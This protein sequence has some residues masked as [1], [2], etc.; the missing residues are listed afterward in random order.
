MTPPL[1]VPAATGPV[2]GVSSCGKE[3]LALGVSSSSLNPSQEV[4][5]G[6]ADAFV[7]G[8][9]SPCGSTLVP[10]RSLSP[11][12][13]SYRGGSERETPICAPDAKAAA[14][15]QLPSSQLRTQHIFLWL[16]PQ[17]PWAWSTVGAKSMSG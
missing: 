15:P 4:L 9:G 7:W 5:R 11:L 16:L 12:Y 2:C 14:A 17:P 6:Q 3:N 8:L 1:G 13:Q 10:R